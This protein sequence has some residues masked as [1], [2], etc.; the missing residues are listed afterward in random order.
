M[1]DK[2]NQIQVNIKKLNQYKSSYVK[3]L[4]VYK[5]YLD[6][7][8]KDEIFLKKIEGI[9]E[10]LNIQV[11]KIDNTIERLENFANQEQT[12]KKQ[13]KKLNKKILQISDNFTRNSIFG[14][15][16]I[17][18]YMKKPVKLENTEE[19]NIPESNDTLLISEILQK[20]ILPYRGEEI[21]E[22]LNSEKSSYKTAE[23][24]IEGE[25]T[26]KLSDFRFQKISRF[27]ETMKLA[28][29]REKFEK[30]DAITLAFE[31]MG[32]RY[33]HPAIIAACRNLDELDVYL[34]CL[35]KNELEDFK[36][37]KIKYELYP[38]VVKKGIFSDFKKVGKHEYFNEMLPNEA[39]IVE[40]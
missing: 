34:D 3:K 6:T 25:F 30:L 22:F 4:G 11:L 23:E 13:Y 19:N 7:F 12:D 36:I 18:E 24:V 20:V 2:L 14:E 1:S 29:A 37:F 15:E 40:K 5:G 31:M 39:D 10:I 35:D 21:Q 28:R 26:R 16:I 38:A 9:I 32:K 33:L 17:A 8:S 27:V